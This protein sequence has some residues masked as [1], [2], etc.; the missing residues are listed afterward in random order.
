MGIQKNG[1]K[2][3]SKTVIVQARENNL[4]CFR[5]GFTVSKKVN[6][7]AVVR[8]RIKRRLREIARAVILTKAAP[9]YDFV[10]IGRTAT[11]DV[12]Y[13]NLLNDLQWCL[14]RMECLKK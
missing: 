1:R 8:N 9:G 6:K 12:P 14:K 10:L 3:V 5:V 4:G 13:E 2:W 7:R 11:G